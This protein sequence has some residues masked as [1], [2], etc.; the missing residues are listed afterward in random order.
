MKINIEID[1]RCFVKEEIIKSAICRLATPIWLDPRCKSNHPCPIRKF[2]TV[3]RE[4]GRSR[5]HIFICIT[6]TSLS[7]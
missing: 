7:K 3:R 1:W 6:A 4:S 5:T 2:H